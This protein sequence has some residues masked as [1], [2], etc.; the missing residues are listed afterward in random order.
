MFVPKSGSFE[1]GTRHSLVGKCSPIFIFWLRSS[2]LFGLFCFLFCPSQHRRWTTCR[3]T[4]RPWTS[5]NLLCGS[6]S[7]TNHQPEK[8]PENKK[9]IFV[10]E[11]SNFVRGF[12]YLQ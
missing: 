5:Q 1:L 2:F 3:W 6:Y 12:V 11:G 4:T 10:T 7:M 9:Y 8:N